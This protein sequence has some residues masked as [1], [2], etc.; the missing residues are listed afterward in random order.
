MLAQVET[1]A[2]SAAVDA[3]QFTEPHHYTL[4]QL[5]MMVDQEL[6]RLGREW[7]MSIGGD[8]T[9]SSLLLPL[10]AFVSARGKR[11]RPLLVLS[12][13][14]G[15]SPAIEQSIVRIAASVEL[16]H[17]F[18]L[19]HDDIIDGARRRRGGLSL[20]REYGSRAFGDE[21]A[22][23]GPSMAM[24]AS[25]MLFAYALDTLSGAIPLNERGRAALHT[26][27][28]AAVKTGCGQFGEVARTAM[29]ISQ[30]T[31]MNLWHTCDLKTSYYSF[32][33]P[34]TVG[35]IL[36]GAPEHAADRL[37]LAGLQ[38]GRAYQ[39]QHDLEGIVRGETCGAKSAYTDLRSATVTLPILRLYRRSTSETRRAHIERVLSEPQP[40]VEACELIR[41]WLL[42]SDIPDEI[43][44]EACR[45]RN[46]ALDIIERTPCAP[47]ALALLKKVVTAVM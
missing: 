44:A 47:R 39:L 38:L 5:R 10:T 14:L 9:E 22:R 16:M 43:R 46:S 24:V 6:G 3:L 11:L 42:E 4:N 36:G 7:L 17:D 20:H 35:A 28:R 8:E 31:E 12:A 19:V 40:A 34:L 25:D 15:W 37:G 21:E 1:L 26:L 32:Q 18:A 2:P 27:M 45:F 30:M 23:H 29:P 41:R 13:Y 33:A